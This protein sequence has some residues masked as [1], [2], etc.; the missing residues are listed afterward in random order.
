MKTITRIILAV[1]AFSTFASISP[2]K[3]QT[4][5]FVLQR[6]GWSFDRHDILWYDGK[7]PAKKSGN[8]EKMAGWAEYDFVVPS[9]GWY[10]LIFKGSVPGWDRD[11]YLD[12]VRI[13]HNISYPDDILGKDG[14]FKQANLALTSGKHT[15]RVRRLG[16]PGILPS[17]WELRAAANTPAS[18][19]FAQVV[20]RNIIRAGES[21]TVKV[22]GGAPIAT[23]YKLVEHDLQTG[24]DVPVGEVAFPVSS[25]FVTKTV[26]LPCPREGVF[27]LRAVAGGTTLRHSDFQPISY[28]VVDTKHA[29]ATTAASKRTIVHDIDCVAQTDSGKALAANVDFWEANGGTRV[30]KSPAGA[31]RESGDNTGPAK[32]LTSH[33]SKS[34][35]AFSYRVDVPD[36]QKPYLLELDYPDDD[37]R[38]AN[39]IIVEHQQRDAN[40]PGSGYETGDWYP[41]TMKMQTHTVVFWPMTKELRVAVVSMNPNMRA[42]AARI[43][44]TRLDDGVPAGSANRPDGRRYGSWFEE[45]NRWLMHFRS[46]TPDRTELVQDYVGVQRWIETCRY[47]GI[48]YICPTEQIYQGVIYD[49]AEM[50]GLFTRIYDVPRVEALLCE[51][52]GLNYVPELHLIPGNDWFKTRV[53]A[54]LTPNFDDL[55]MRN[56]YGAVGLSGPYYSPLNPAVQDKYVRVVGELADKI[57]DTKA[58]GGISL[59]L[60][61]WQWGSFNAFP[62]LAWGYEDCTVSQ[63]VKD[64]GIAVP[65][66]ASDPDRYAKR[67]AFLTAPKM[68]ER[69]IDWRC[70]KMLAL[71]TRL[72]DRIQKNHPGAVIYLA[73][74]PN[75]SG[76]ETLDEDFGSMTDTS[77]DQVR[78]TGI[79]S[80]L[81]A[82]TP[83]VALMPF[84]YYGRRNSTPVAD[85]QGFDRELDPEHKA[86]GMGHERAFGYGN[87]YFEVHEQIPIDMLGFPDLKPTGYNGAADASGRTILERLSVVLADQDT[88]TML[89]GGFGYVFGQPA[90][91]NEWLGEYKQLPRLPFA[92]L[93]SGRDPVAV[94]SRDCDDGYYFYAVNRESYAV[95]I[96]LKLSGA[97]SVT[98]LG[99]GDKVAVMGGALS[100]T[101][102]PYELRAFRTDRHA[103]VTSCTEN[104]P[105]EQ[106][107]L[108]KDRLAYCQALAR[109]I[110]T[111]ERRGDVTAKERAEYLAQLATAWDAF[112][113]SHYWRARTALSMTPMIAVFDKLAAYPDGQLHR[114]QTDVLVTRN[115][116]REEIPATPMLSGDTLAKV[117]VGT[118]PV[119]VESASYDPNWAH[120]QVFQATNGKLDIDLPVAV[121][122][123]YRLSVG[124]VATGAANVGVSVNGKDLAATV[125]IAD[126]NRPMRSVLPLVTL[127]AGVAHISLHAQGAFGVYGV[128]LQQVYTPLSSDKWMTA[129]P[130]P[131]E[132]NR[133]PGF[134]RYDGK[135][136]KKALAIPYIPESQPIDLAATSPG[137]DGKQVA[138][139]YSDD[140]HGRFMDTGVNF[141]MRS[142]VMYND[143][144]YAVTYVTSP[145]DRPATLYVGVDWWANSY[146][147]GVLLPSPRE[148][149]YTDDDGAQLNAHTPLAVPLSLK[150]GVNTLL[151][152]CHGGSA[153]NYFI[154]AISDPG[155]LS[156]SPKP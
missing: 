12:G 133:H 54:K 115:T 5:P 15:L 98:G 14:S 30:T 21:L 111:G 61:N 128:T 114:S 50:D 8:I 7:E 55:L 144:C 100:L 129:G 23:A 70:R 132:W 109:A 38:T 82:K 80:N 75:P 139:Q 32:V 13:F 34:L 48:N 138:W 22:T 127:P 89:D 60:M 110:T 124:A 147:N 16:F 79:D 4:K 27:D 87:S 143:V 103:A 47:T 49:S 122:G 72:R 137:S 10:E 37:R 108:V 33:G 142:G 141:L 1:C 101:L 117:I 53:M 57:S 112:K 51:K 62:S 31:Y 123:R 85:Q 19:I 156:V 136:V 96:S 149:K 45:P 155:D 145:E 97:K 42:A 125:Q 126:A 26:S 64:T 65:G 29:P 28:V 41:V 131:S 2:S 40:Q 119:V 118:A 63:F 36:V 130:F 24:A 25:T 43:R 52:Y 9:Q 67:F 154:A 146:L 58:F 84:G 35:S 59:R 78:E 68:R 102:K 39:V 6:D 76:G 91:F 74:H 56:R 44:V 120:T 150:K 148:K 66:A 88:S 134:D 3:A 73:K 113:Q 152:K 140:V 92:P 71:Y 69:W 93:E 11:V 104:V 81:L 105:V 95:P 151:V 46:N 83:G 20:G 106:I 153:G 17:G 116:G 107:E 135:W 18:T 90:A 121:L 94:W 99:H 86:M 77:H